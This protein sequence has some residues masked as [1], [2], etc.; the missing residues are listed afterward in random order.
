MLV[1]ARP[2]LVL[3]PRDYYLSEFFTK[4]ECGITASDIEPNSIREAIRGLCT[5]NELKN[6]CVANALSV[7]TKFNGEGVAE[8]LRG[9][10]RKSV[11]HSVS[12]KGNS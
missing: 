7:A 2:I 12:E 11:T 10:L 6:K 1:A 9:V 8:V 4:H 5:D 3:C